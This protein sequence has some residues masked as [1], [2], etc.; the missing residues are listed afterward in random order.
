MWSLWQSLLVDVGPK[1]ALRA[2]SATPARLTE[3]SRRRSAAA[4][5]ARPSADEW[6]AIEILAHLRACADVWGSS[7]QRMIDEDHPTIRYVSP[8]GVMRKPEYTDR[9]F[10]QSLDLFVSARKV[11]VKTLR[12]LPPEGWS[13]GATI[14]ARTKGQKSTVLD[15]ARNIASHEAAHIVQFEALFTTVVLKQ[16]ATER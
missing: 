4:L 3:L 7:I 2:L 8:R 12:V 1:A 14:T 13:L 16:L 10:K 11:L 9:G 15:H 6:S 5:A